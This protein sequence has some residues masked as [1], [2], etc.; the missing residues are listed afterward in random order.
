M[1][2]CENEMTGCREF[3]YR[4]EVTLASQFADD[5]NCRRLPERI[6]QCVLHVCDSHAKNALCE[7]QLRC[8]GLQKRQKSRF[9]VFVELE[10]VGLYRITDGHDVRRTLQ[11][12]RQL[13]QALQIPKQDGVQILCFSRA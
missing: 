8:S 7:V 10:Y 2:C 11:R 13:E 6:L 3:K 5:H 12:S 9:I 4:L 1:R